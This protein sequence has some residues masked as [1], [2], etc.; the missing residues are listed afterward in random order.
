MLWNKNKKFIETLEVKKVTSETFPSCTG[1]RCTGFLV[2]WV[3][4]VSSIIM[5]LSGKGKD[6]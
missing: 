1:P 5:S 3:H 6:P 2:H 4:F